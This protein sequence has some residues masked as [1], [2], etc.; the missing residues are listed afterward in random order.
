MGEIRCLDGLGNEYAF[1]E[2][3]FVDRQAVYGVLLENNQVLLVRDATSTFWELPGGGIETGEGNVEALKREFLEES[4]LHIQ[5]PVTLINSFTE[6]YYDLVSRQPWKT[7]RSF[8]F[9]ENATGAIQCEGNTDDITSVSMVPINELCHY[10]IKGNIQSI[11]ESAFRAHLAR[12]AS[13]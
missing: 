10:H 7:E 9:V 6:R 8:Y 13:A 4:G 11:I 2:D 5:G 1:E 12:T 3:D